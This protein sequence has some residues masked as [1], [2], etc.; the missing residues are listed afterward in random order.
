MRVFSV[1]ILHASVAQAITKEDPVDTVADMM[2]DKLIDKLAHTDLDGTTL[3]KPSA[4]MGT[5]TIMRAAQPLVPPTV[6]IAQDRLRAQGISSSPLE[7]L[8]LTAID[9]NNRGIGMRNVQVMAANLPSQTREALSKLHKDVVVKAASMTETSTLSKADMAGG[10][11]PLGDFWDPMGFSAEVSGTQLAFF[12]EAEL[13]HGRLGM[14]ATLGF[15]AGE[16]FSPLFGATDVTTPATKLWGQALPAVPEQFWGAI[17][18][19]GSFLEL[20]ML[21]AQQNNPSLTEPGDFGFDPL[22]MKPKDAKGLK[23][24]QNKELN[25]GRLAMLAAAGIIAQELV[26]G[27]KIF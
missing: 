15:I 22:G 23:E 12:R 1:I 5:P 13:K 7:T 27:Q 3:G 14:L 19:A 9:A 16:K 6:R 21:N 11:A 2:L 26:T 4:T 25:N 18:V 8:A 20:F 24:M 17:I 10:T